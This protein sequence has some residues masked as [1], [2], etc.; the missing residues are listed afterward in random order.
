MRAEIGYC[1]Q[2][3]ALLDLMTT[4]EHLEFY[5][6]LKGVPKEKASAVA[7]KGQLRELAVQF[8]AAIR[9]V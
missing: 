1:P 4:I 6:V 8:G 9:F 2:E 3:N 7:S 5:A